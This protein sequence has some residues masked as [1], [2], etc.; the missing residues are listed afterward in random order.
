MAK[1][2]IMVCVDRGLWKTAR[3]RGLNLSKIAN[4]ALKASLGQRDELKTRLAALRTESDHIQAMLGNPIE[5][6]NEI[7]KALPMLY[8]INHWRKGAHA[9]DGWL[10]QDGIRAMFGDPTDDQID[11]AMEQ[12]IVRKRRA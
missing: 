10:R 5:L 7:E 4:D 6:A 11:E 9:V 12:I 1:H 2:R 8:E 3:A